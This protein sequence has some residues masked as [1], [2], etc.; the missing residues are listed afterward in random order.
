[1]PR[2]NISVWNSEQPI[3]VKS[4][5]TTRSFNTFLVSERS[6]ASMNILN[7]TCCP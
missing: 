3:A 7:P 6:I 4:V 1:M 2:Q 5:Y